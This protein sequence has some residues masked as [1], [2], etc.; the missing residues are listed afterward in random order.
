MLIMP[1]TEID[2]QGLAENI[3]AD[4]FGRGIALADGVVKVAKENDFTPEEIKRLVEKTNTQASI[5]MLKTA[6]DKKA[7]FDLVHFA[8]VLARTH[9]YGEETEEK[10]AS[11][12]TGLPIKQPKPV[13]EKNAQE[14]VE[15]IPDID[16][17]DALHCLHDNLENARLKKVACELQ[18]EKNISELCQMFNHAD[19]PDFCKFANEAEDYFGPLAS[20]TLEAVAKYLRTPLEKQA[21]TGVIDDTTLP[22]QKLAEIC[23]GLLDYEK[24]DTEISILNKLAENTKQALQGYLR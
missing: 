15:E 10:M 4:F 6:E 11:L 24:L 5:H 13:L 23:H 19:A 1:S 17:F 3:S 16:A 2:F 21:C 18:L 9:P 8:E 14:E 22:M 20:G 12:Y 7:C